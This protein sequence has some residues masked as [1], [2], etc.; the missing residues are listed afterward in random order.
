MHEDARVAALPARVAVVLCARVRG[1]AV[2]ADVDEEEDVEGAV[3]PVEDVA[4][5]GGGR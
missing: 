5:V 2:D 1:A 4:S 3:Y